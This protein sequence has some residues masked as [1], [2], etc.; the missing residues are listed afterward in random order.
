M[1]SM[2]IGGS[3]LLLGV[4]ELLVK[5]NRAK[6]HIF[7]LI[8][9]LGIGQ[10][11]FNA[12]IFRRDWED[13]RNIY[14]Q[15]AWR[16]PALQPNTILLTHQMPIDYETDAS[17][18][19]PINWTYAPNYSR[20]D[21]PYL[22][23][24]TEKRVGGGTLPALK[25]NIP[26]TFNY[27]TVSFYG[28][29][30]QAVVIY[31]PRGGCLRVLDPAQGDTETYSRLP[32]TLT[33]AIPLSNPSRIIINPET[34]ATP[35]FFSEP[36]HEWCY[37]FTKAEL[38]QQAGNYQEVISLGTEAASL[39]YQPTDQNEWLV[40]IKAHA[41]TGNLQTAKSI[42]TAALKEDARVRRGVCS[43]WRQIQNQ[44]S[45]ENKTEID[46]IVLAFECKPQ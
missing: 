1:I 19:A 37:Y 6:N 20:S 29:T 8:I 33:D 26:I 22:M 39:G 42:S 18:T 43:A 38:A 11:F 10:Q 13:Q 15:M 40:F 17:F 21:V 36:K 45:A 9:A 12:N 34:V 46:Q 24:Y 7:A 25:P 28:N 41:L 30:S 14:W 3:L 32:A 5:N 23:L 31:M 35:M 4:I 16:I 2:M 44:E 27:R